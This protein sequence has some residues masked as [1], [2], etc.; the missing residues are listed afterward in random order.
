MR[1]GG[2]LQARLHKTFAHGA[3]RPEL[4]RAS[5]AGGH[6]GLDVAGMAGIKLAVD[7]RVQQDFGFVAGHDPSSAFHAVRSMA[8]A[9]ASRDITV[10]TGAPDDVGDLAIGK[11]VDFPQ[12]D[13]L[14]ERLRQGADQAADRGVVE[15]AQ[16]LRFGRGLR[17]LPHRHFFLRGVFF[18]ASCSAPVACCGGR[19]RR[20]RR[21]SGSPTATASSPARDSC[22]NGAAPADSIPA[23][24]L[25]H[26]RRC[27]SGS[28]PA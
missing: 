24:R 3:E 22:R 19:T 20:R 4:L 26:R 7:E 8:R 25:R 6:V 11:V 14:A 23:P 10:P 9:R 17:L 12:H 16:Q 15:A 21:S 13:G 5:G 1:R 18:G 2:F 27:A 28:A